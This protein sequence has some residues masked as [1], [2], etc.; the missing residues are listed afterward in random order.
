MQAHDTSM[1]VV[2][3]M[4]SKGYGVKMYAVTEGW[5]VC[6]EREN[7][8]ICRDKNLSMA[9]ALASLRAKGME[10]SEGG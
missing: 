6:F 7:Y 10:I 2:E 8:Y 3:K 4:R 9:I 5:S 1:E